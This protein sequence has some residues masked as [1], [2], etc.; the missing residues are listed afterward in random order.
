MADDGL[1]D[2]VDVV[3]LNLV[4]ELFGQALSHDHAELFLFDCESSH[5]LRGL[6]EEL[7]DL[8][9]QAREV[10]NAGTLAHNLGVEDFLEKT[11]ANND[12]AAA[13]EHN[14]EDF[15]ELILNELIISCLVP[16]RLKAVQEPNDEL[17][18]LDVR[19]RQGRAILFNCEEVVELVQEIS[20]QVLDVDGLLGGVGQLVYESQVFVRL[21]G[22]QRIVV[23]IVFKEVFDLD[24]QLSS[25]RLLIVEFCE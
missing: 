2:F 25:Q 1:P 18:P 14:F 6:V 15:L 21:R 13:D 12:A 20:E 4:H 24:D 17:A 8:V 22:H 19:F 5:R 7:A 9:V 11:V 3:V 10:A 23:P 16:P